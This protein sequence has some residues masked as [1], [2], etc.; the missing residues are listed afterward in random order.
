MGNTYEWNIN[1]ENY[2]NKPIKLTYTTANNQT[3]STE[4]TG[5]TS[6][7][8]QDNLIKRILSPGSFDISFIIFALI[9]LIFGI[10]LIYFYNKTNKKDE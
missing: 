8:S 5:S 3:S 4:S 1:K 2:K 9:F 6:N 10:V 7:S